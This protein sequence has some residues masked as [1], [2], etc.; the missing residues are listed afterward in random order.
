[1]NI[2]TL[3]KQVPDI[4]EIKI[5][6]KTSTLSGKGRRIDKNIP[7]LNEASMAKYFANESACSAADEATRIFDA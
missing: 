1:M 7:C 2:V 4:I 3:I 6:P 5:D